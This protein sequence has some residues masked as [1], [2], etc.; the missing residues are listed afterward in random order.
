MVFL[1][2]LS[3][4]KDRKIGYRTFASNLFVLSIET[5]DGTMSSS[6]GLF[7]GLSLVSESPKPQKDVV[8]QNESSAE[9]SAVNDSTAVPVEP[10]EPPPTPVADAPVTDKLLGMLGLSEPTSPVRP[11]PT[12][13]AKAES[14]PGVSVS[15]PKAMPP[16]SPP[17]RKLSRA[18]VPGTA[19]TSTP[20]VTEKSPVVAFSKPTNEA[21]EEMKAPPAA[22]LV[23]TD[24]IQAGAE[25]DAEV[26][27]S[28]MK[29]PPPTPISS[30]P[31]KSDVPQEATTK[32]TTT[33]PVAS[34][35]ADVKVTVKVERDAVVDAAFRGD[36]RKSP[37]KKP[38]PRHIG[39]VH[40]DTPIP[41]CDVALRLLRKF[42][43]KTRPKI[44]VDSGGTKSNGILG[45]FLGPAETEAALVPYAELMKVIITPEQD[46]SNA[47]VDSILGGSGDS[48]AKA[49]LAMA[50]LCH[51]LSVW[52]HAST[53]VEV[54]KNSLALDLL[55]LCLDTTTDLVAHGCLDGVILVI[56]EEKAEYRA[57]QML[58]EAIFVTDLHNERIELATLKFLLTTGCRTTPEGEALL[59]GTHL[60]QSIRVLY[61]IYLTTPTKSNKTTAR[62]SLQQLVT[63]VFKRMIKTP[64]ALFQKDSEG[65]P[66]SNHRDGFLVL[67]S[68]CK[69]SMRT[70]PGPSK[71]TQNH[72]G[73]QT[74]NSNV[75]WDGGTKEGAQQPRIMR[76]SDNPL[77]RQDVP[78]N[79]S[80][81]VVHPALES[82]VLAL[83][84][85][86]Y[87]LQNTDMSGGFLQTTGPQFQYAVRNY[88]CVSL[89]KNC[90]SDNTK[91]V[92][93]SLRLFV[94]LVRNFRSHLK[95]EIEAF[96]TNVFFV[97]L[98]SKHSTVEHKTL[99]VVLFKEICSDPQTLAEIFLNYDCDLSAV[100]LF[101]RIVN[102]LSRVAKAGVQ[103][104]ATVTSMSFVAGAGAARMEKMRNENRQ[105]RLDAM[106]SLRQ[107]LA[108][109]HASIVEPVVKREQSDDADEM[110]TTP[111]KSAR[112]AAATAETNGDGKHSLVQI[113]DSKKKRRE[114]EAEVILRFNRKPTKGIKYASEC[115]HVDD[116]DPV[117]V[118]R[119]LLKNKDVFDKTQT[120]E[121]L[122][123]EPDYQDGF[124]IKV[125]HAYVSMMDFTGLLFDDAIKNFLSG[126]RL[127][128]E[129]QKVS[130]HDILL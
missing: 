37:R 122:G 101:H 118:A 105:L 3:S 46:E 8:E 52:C 63:S 100:D 107:V 125:L 13:P 61:H 5:F 9:K 31:V 24:S 113:Y 117:D 30:K 57:I 6:G 119:Y 114:E 34:P 120:G 93:L 50:T 35:S 21:T 112:D 88:L 56:G 19:N 123:R 130:I 72:A 29:T 116:K 55:A 87:V 89:L 128:G 1:V 65:F 127:P 64:A 75:M 129:A 77:T 51:L 92:N 110:T 96:V 78:H 62:A 74:S 59:R 111:Q 104:E 83:E 39:V 44:S 4:P 53:R 76:E 26:A 102:T 2:W 14:S 68:M 66:S 86:L 36:E 126:F 45:F 121:F 115:G 12:M 108:S 85:L 90:T 43:A 10:T 41:N 20:E 33:E 67:R 99:V 71:P 124:S 60:L 11:P 17:Q 27:F 28:A 69:L 82:K 91:V 42:A 94:P 106:R 80:S 81:K 54:Q 84:L 103:D 95:T 25:P 109:L 70:L 16:K 32:A 38:P 98:D 22:S 18:S 79:L 7:A 48:M 40:E 97:I 47:V 49:R 58:C 23:S 15:F 73:L